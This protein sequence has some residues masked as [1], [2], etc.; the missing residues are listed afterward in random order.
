[1]KSFLRE[2]SFNGNHSS[3]FLKSFFK[4]PLHPPSP[5]SNQ[6][7][8]LF[9]WAHIHLSCKAHLFKIADLDAAILVGSLRLFDQNYFL[10]LAAKT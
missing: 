10:S 1:M 8:P 2:Y 3:Y 9:S 5:P 4:V 7:V 6:N